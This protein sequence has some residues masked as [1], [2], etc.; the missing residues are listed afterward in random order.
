MTTIDQRTSNLRTVGFENPLLAALGIEPMSVNELRGRTPQGWLERPERVDF[1]M[2][3]LV[4]EGHT[5]HTVDFVD[6][7]LLPGSLVFVRPGQVQQW[8]HSEGLQAQLI[9]V[10]PGTLPHRSELMPY[11]DLRRLGL[12]DWVTCISLP[13]SAR[14]AIAGG[15]QKIRADFAQFSGSSL[16][17]ALLRHELMALLIRVARQQ[18]QLHLDHP[19][20]DALRH[21]T[22]RLF[23]Q[24]LEQTFATEHQLQYYA[25]RLGYSQSAVSRACLSAEGRSAKNVIS[26]RI[27]L[28]AKRLLAHS[29]A[30]VAQVAHQL[31]FSE[32]TNFVKFFR[33]GAGMTPAR[34]RHSMSGRAATT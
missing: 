17:I 18:Q 3:L 7:N 30:S 14:D 9:L 23:I 29:D 19:P 2:L 27:L 4:L 28:E 12:D 10:D 1:F 32:P 33:K 24:L 16:D 34:F 15:F 8:H 5:T 11:S 13:E 20:A 21:K 31:G 6:W 22:Y 25:K 26:A